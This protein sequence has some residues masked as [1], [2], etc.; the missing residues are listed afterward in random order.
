[1]LNIQNSRTMYMCTHFYALY[2]TYVLKYRSQKPVGSMLFLLA[3]HSR[4]LL[5]VH[6][7]V[8]P[9]AIAE[10]NRLDHS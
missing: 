8:V 10:I 7:S 5:G 3:L 2:T 1:M 6:Q 4:F 9:R